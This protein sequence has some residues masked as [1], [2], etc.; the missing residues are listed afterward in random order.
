MFDRDALHLLQQTAV[1]AAKEAIQ[2]ILVDGNAVALATIDAEG[3][4]KFVETEK[5]GEG[6]FRFRGKFSTSRVNEFTNYVT[7]RATPD[8]P[9]Q[10]FIQPDTG[11]ANAFFNLGNPAKPGHGDDT[12]HLQLLQDPA[13][14]AM[15]AIATGQGVSQRALSDFLEDWHLQVGVLVGVEAENTMTVSQ[16]VQ[17]IRGVTVR[18]ENETTRVVGDTAESRSEMDSVAAQVKGGGALPLGF[19]FYAA[20]FDGFTARTWN[21]RLALVTGA[22]DPQ[23]T[24]RVVGADAIKQEVAREFEHLVRQGVPPTVAVYRGVFAP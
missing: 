18:R 8:L 20:P 15:L 10:V 9:V 23:F 17:L 6:R 5:W 13:Y 16:A 24:L 22:K 12:A 4:V 1:I 2:P 21:L 3:G 14:K 11:T 7:A 19:T